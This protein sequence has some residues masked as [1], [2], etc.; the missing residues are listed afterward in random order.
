[1]QRT[2]DLLRLLPEGGVSALDVGARDG[3]FAQLL[4]ERYARVVALDLE[5]PQFTHPKVE[6]VQGNATKLQYAD[7]SFDLVFCAEVLE[8]IPMPFLEQACAE[9][10][11][12]SR[13]HV[14]IGVPFRQDTRVGRT[15]CRACGQPNPPWGHVNSFDEERLARLFSACDVVTTSFVGRS[16]E[17][18]NAV[19]AFLMDLAGNPYGTYDQDESCI[20]CGRAL[21]KPA[22]RSL[23]QKLCTKAGFYTRSL[24][25]PWKGEHP[26]WVHILFAKREG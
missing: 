25:R 9:L 15:T 17:S 19:S 3:H 11:R 10:A 20:H 23:F 26:N 24:S 6:C 2:G 21:E 5:K 8:H 7:A 4:A 12:V 14:L 13:K 1:M 22:E 18:T 16:N